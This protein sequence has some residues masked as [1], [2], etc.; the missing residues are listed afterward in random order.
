MGLAFNVTDPS[1]ANGART[2]RENLSSFTEPL[3]P[4]TTCEGCAT[5]RQRV[6]T[7]ATNDETIEFHTHIYIH[8]SRP[9]H[10]RARARA[11]TPHR[12]PTRDPYNSPIA[13]SHAPSIVRRSRAFLAR[14]VRTRPDMLTVAEFIFQ[15]VVLL[16]LSCGC[17]RSCGRGK[18]RACDC[19]ARDP[20]HA[21]RRA[22]FPSFPADTQVVSPGR[23]R[24]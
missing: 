22:N 14:D 4:T 11:A 23:D 24:S 15:G 21:P 3:P 10:R 1:P 9:R 17:V 16:L 5:M 8:R 2:E 6:S 18:G 7:R 12:V 13:F 20:R 19:D